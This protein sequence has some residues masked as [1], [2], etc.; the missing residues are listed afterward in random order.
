MAK[1]KALVPT[2]L[3]DFEC[4]GNKCEDT[5]CKS[6]TITV[7]KHT[8]KKY[9][10]LKKGHY[11]PILSNSVSLNKEKNNIYNYAEIKLNSDNYCPLLNENGLCSIYIN[12][13]YDYMP[14]TCKVYPRK[15][16]KIDGE[17]E[18]SLSPSCPE[19]VRKALLSKDKME[20]EYTELEYQDYMKI[21]NQFIY[22]KKDVLKKEEHRYF[23]DIRIA[24][25]SILQ[26]R[27]FDIVA[28]LMLLGMMYKKIENCIKNNQ[29]YLIVEEISKFM[30]IVENADISDI[31]DKIEKNK[32]IQAYISKIMINIISSKNNG[33]KT[34]SFV[35]GAKKVFETSNDEELFL[36]GLSIAKYKIFV[37]EGVN[38]F[39]KKNSHIIENYLVNQYFFYCMP[40]GD[41]F[42]TI[43]DSLMFLCIQYLMLKT[44]MIGS[45]Y[46]KNTIN[47]EDMVD[48]IYS[49]CRD[50]EHKNNY[51]KNIV[52]GTHNLEFDTLG[53]LYILIHD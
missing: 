9:K 4:I 7:D 25:I 39:I 6:W 32:E 20:F 16:N 17:I 2:Y 31:F 10:K 24:S 47:E 28:R 44:L 33:E 34:I 45:M 14:L 52:E 1:I 26:N 19:V 37:E 36:D 48:I 15:I 30:N 8:Y 18:M 41:E 46:I 53:G 51:H 50:L 21:A 40:F 23:W 3:K 43:W 38:P 22:T 11:N 49:M 27:K 12:L 42:E 5:C 35:K 29:Y 13:S